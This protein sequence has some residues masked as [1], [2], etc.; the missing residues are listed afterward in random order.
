MAKTAPLSAT[1]S[2]ARQVLE[3]RAAVLASLGSNAFQGSAPLTHN[4]QQAWHRERH[5]IERVLDETGEQDPVLATLDRW[6]ARTTAFQAKAGRTDAGWTDRQ[7][8]AWQADQVL[9]L[10]ADLRD[11]LSSWREKDGTP[12]PAPA[13]AGNAAPPPTDTGSSKAEPGRAGG[14]Q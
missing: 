12:P 3:Q 11:R 10:I 14:S 4:L 2:N 1:P 8:M 5:L 6:E 7:G 13:A 9:A